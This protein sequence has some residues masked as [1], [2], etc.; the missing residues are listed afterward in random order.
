ML[1]NPRWRRNS[2]ADGGTRGG[3]NPSLI[4]NP[5]Q[6]LF[7]LR[8]PSVIRVQPTAVLLGFC[9]DAVYFFVDEGLID[10]IGATDGVELLFDGAYINSLRYNAK[11]KAKAVK[12]WR[13]RNH[14]KNERQKANRLK[15][16]NETATL[17]SKAQPDCPA[18]SRP[19]SIVDKVSGKI[20]KLSSVIIICGAFLVGSSARSVTADYQVP[21]RHIRRKKHN[22]NKLCG[23]VLLLSGL[24]KRPRAVRAQRHAPE[25]SFRQNSG[26]YPRQDCRQT[27][28]HHEVRS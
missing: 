15:K 10:A 3:Q 9:V 22:H 7:A 18:T 13:A 16:Q 17:R 28:F 12:A 27:T 19:S 6:I 8:V 21:A 2:S 25:C 1:P 23:K 11:W 14:E 20:S 5:D 24:A 26:Q 4:M